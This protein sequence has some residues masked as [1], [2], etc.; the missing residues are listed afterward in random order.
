MGVGRMGRDRRVGCSFT[1]HARVSLLL[2]ESCKSYIIIAFLGLIFP[3]FFC[4]VLGG[5]GVY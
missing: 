5:G 2:F 3:S 4:F 1:F